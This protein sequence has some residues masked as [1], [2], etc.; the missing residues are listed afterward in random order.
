MADDR[1]HAEMPKQKM[2]PW[3]DDPGLVLGM[4]ITTNAIGWTLIRPR[5]DSIIDR[6]RDSYRALSPEDATL[7]KWQAAGCPENVKLYK[8][9]NEEAYRASPD[10]EGMSRATHSKLVD[11]V[12][13]KLRRHGALVTIET[14]EEPQVYS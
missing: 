10:K 12:A 11:R 13:A 2:E 14:V 9:A 6:G 7:A 3:G 4:K 8:Y 1:K 5:K